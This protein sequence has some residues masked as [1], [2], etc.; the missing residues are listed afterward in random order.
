MNSTQ[1]LGT[2]SKC[3]GKGRI[4]AFSHY[5]DGVCFWCKG[6]GK[7]PASATTPGEINGANRQAR[8]KALAM[9]VGLAADGSSFDDVGAAIVSC[10]QIAADLAASGPKWAMAAQAWQIVVD[11]VDDA[12]DAGAITKERV[13]CIRVTI[14]RLRASWF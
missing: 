9:K 11:I 4:R 13:G 2:C 7:L 5:A 8:V 12:L 6:A 3:D 1:H 14:P 10:H